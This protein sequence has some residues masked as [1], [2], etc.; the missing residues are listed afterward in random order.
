MSGSRGSGMSN[1]D[2]EPGLS[3]P[4]TWPSVT[5][6]SGV[7][8]DAWQVVRQVVVVHGLA[9]SKMR[10][11]VDVTR[12]E[13]RSGLV[14][15]RQIRDEWPPPNVAGSPGCSALPSGPRSAS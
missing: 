14:R 15:V 2:W 12:D 13:W 7:S 1:W 6:M 10:D 9:Q 11:E 5:V 8:S 4:G 3:D